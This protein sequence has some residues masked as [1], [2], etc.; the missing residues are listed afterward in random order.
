MAKR[1]VAALVTD[2]VV[3]DVAGVLG[4]GL[5]V[6]C[7]GVA[8]PP[9]VAGLTFVDWQ[10]PIGCGGV[11]VFP[12]DLI[13]VDDDG[14]VLIPAALVDEVVADAI[15]QERLEGW[16][17]GEVDAAHRCPACIRRMPK[18]RRA[19]RRGP[20]GRQASAESP[21]RTRCQSR[22]PGDALMIEHHLDIAAADGTMNT[23]VVH[24]EEGGPH[25]GGAVLHGRAGQAR[26]AAR[27]GA[28]ARRGGLLR[29]A[30]QPVLPPHARVRPE[31]AHR[32]A[33]GGDVRAHAHARPRTPVRDTEAMLQFVDAQPLA[34]RAASAPWATA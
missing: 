28:A 22:T 21:R 33:D 10:E 20:R 34:E 2:G 19:T 24:P 29:R 23:F 4:T 13:V 12:D 5:P 30:A 3:R 16:I 11:A 31:G 18:T 8:A 9:S 32:G 14:A 7:Q 25:P 15:E 6:W 26:R 1:G 27:H 17:M